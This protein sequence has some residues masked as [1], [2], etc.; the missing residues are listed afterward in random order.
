MLRG[1]NTGNDSP[2]TMSRGADGCLRF[3][4]G[5]LKANNSATRVSEGAD[6][7]LELLRGA[8]SVVKVK[9]SA[10]KVSSGGADG[11][12]RLLRGANAANTLLHN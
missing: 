4:R 7:H 11:C 3:L 5:D 8:N 2:T 10:T 12:S 1:A 6:G 9:G